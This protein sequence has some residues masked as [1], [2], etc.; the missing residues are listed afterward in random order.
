[1]YGKSTYQICGKKII[2]NQV[3]AERIELMSY[4]KNSNQY[5]NIHSSMQIN[6]YL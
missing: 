2:L 5:K 4:L 3:W 6:R 1:M